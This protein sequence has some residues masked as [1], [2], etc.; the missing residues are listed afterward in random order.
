MKNDNIKHMEINI[1][2]IGKSIFKKKWK[3]TLESKERL[4]MWAFGRNMTV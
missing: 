2:D 1:L 4:R 3:E